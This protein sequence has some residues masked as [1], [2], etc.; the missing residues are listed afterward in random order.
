MDKNLPFHYWTLNERFSE[1][2]LPSF[3]EKPQ[4]DDQ[5]MEKK[6]S[7]LHMLKINRREDASIFTPGRSFLPVRS[8]QSIRQMLHKPV[9]EL[10]SVPEGF[11][12]SFL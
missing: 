7:R 6:K 4:Q 5:S 1:D 12:E 2:S 3:D 11:E 8:K 9:S 10:P